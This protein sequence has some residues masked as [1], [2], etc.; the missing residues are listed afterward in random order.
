MSLFKVQGLL[1]EGKGSRQPSEPQLPPSTAPPSQEGQV[2]VVTPSHP[3]KTQTPRQAKRGWDT[4]I[5][6]SGD[7]PKKVGN[8]AVHK[9]LGDIVERAATT[10]ASLDAE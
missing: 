4:E 8:E 2:F 5:P 1:V 3:Q 6:Q 10:T 7:P 9:E